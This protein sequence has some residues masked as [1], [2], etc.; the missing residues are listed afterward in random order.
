MRQRLKICRQCSDRVG[1][2]CGINGRSCHELA[3]RNACPYGLFDERKPVSIIITVGPGLAKYLPSALE[4]CRGQG[5]EVIVV[6]DGEPIPPID[7]T[8]HAIKIVEGNWRSVQAA[9]RAG[10]AA[11]SGSAILFLDCDNRLTSGF[12]PRAFEQLRAA[13]SRDPRVA[14]VYPAL[15]YWDERFCRQVGRLD[16]PEWNRLR[17]EC[18]NYVDASCLVWKSALDLSWRSE[19]SHDRL[20]DWATWSDLARDGWTFQ[21]GDNLVLDYRRRPGSMSAVDH[22]PDYATR[23]SL[24]RQRITLFVPLARER[25]WWRLWC[26]IQTAPPGTAIVIA[27]TGGNRPLYELVRRQLATSRFEDVRIYRHQAGRAGLADADRFETEAAVQLAVAE[28]YNRFA[29]ECRSDL[30]L[31]VEDDVLPELPADQLIEELKQGLDE[32]TAAVSGL[33]QSRFTADLV[34]WIGGG[35]RDLQFLDRGIPW[36]PVDRFREVIG[37]GFGCLLVRTEALRAVP[38]AIEPENPWYDP[39]FFERLRR[40]G[41]GVKVARD[42]RCTHGE[43]AFGEMPAHQRLTG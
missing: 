2:S 8:R 21:R 5:A 25:Y 29:Q 18:E 43:Y 3:D 41:F 12:V 34:A 42:V 30:A 28:V 39:R 22:S 37:V 17:F 32:K 23:Y 40:L 7:R 9:R 19:T 36:S 1:N 26:W 14:G 27:E 31:I 33:Y 24:D 38:H 35:G 10:I 13:S 15:A 20:E 11:S 16:P 4:S 6:F